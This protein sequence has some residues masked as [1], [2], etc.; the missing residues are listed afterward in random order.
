MDPILG[1]LPCPHNRLLVRIAGS[2]L[3]L[4]EICDR[5]PPATVIRL[6]A[7]ALL[8]VISLRCIGGLDQ[9]EPFT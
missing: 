5:V 6:A 3:P 2:M 9:Q 8:W 4:C 7:R 1:A